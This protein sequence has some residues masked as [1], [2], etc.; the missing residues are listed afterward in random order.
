[1]KMFVMRDRGAGNYD[2]KCVI[3]PSPPASLQHLNCLDFNLILQH[4]LVEL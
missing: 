3:F 1:M 2:T 4:V